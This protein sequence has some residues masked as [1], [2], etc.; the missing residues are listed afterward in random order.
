MPVP[1]M[2][3]MFCN[4]QQGRNDSILEIRPTFMAYMPRCVNNVQ[5]HRKG[6]FRR[7]KYQGL[8][9]N[10]QGSIKSVSAEWQSVCGPGLHT[11]AAHTSVLGKF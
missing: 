6:E 1:V 2:G 9:I 4:I 3:L 8:C 10:C 7:L 5:I 11:Y